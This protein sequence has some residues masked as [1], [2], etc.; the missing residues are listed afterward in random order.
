VNAFVTLDVPG[1]QKAAAE[2]AARWKA[3]KQIGL[4]DGV[5]VSVKDNLFV[6]GLRATWGSRLFADY[7]APRDDLAVVALRNAGAV[8][9]GKTNTPELALG[10]ST[11]NL[12]F[13]STGNPWDRRLSPGGSSGGAAAGLAAGCGPLA[14]GTDAGG[15]IRRPAGHTGIAGLKPGVGRVPR[16]YGFPALAY[17]LQVVGPMARSVAVLRGLFD[18][19]A[20]PRSNPNR[21]AT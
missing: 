9:L 21:P 4:L 15:S 16:R 14:I 13:G 11:S 5:P 2:S 12:Q 7:V 20:T 3:G 19:I 1:A 17:D 18:L 8:I 6:G 10:G